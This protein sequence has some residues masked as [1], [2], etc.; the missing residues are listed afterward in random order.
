[1][2]Y[3]KRGEKAQISSCKTYRGW[4]SAKEGSAAGSQDGVNANSGSA[5]LRF[6][7]SQSLVGAEGSCA[8]APSE[9]GARTEG[10]KP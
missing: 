7:P 4:K 6:R 3:E 5:S 2:K 9:T 1:M 10:V 8:A